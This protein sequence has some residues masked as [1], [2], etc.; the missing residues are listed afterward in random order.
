[1]SNQNI[2]FATLLPGLAGVIKLILQ[3]FGIEVPD[4][5]INDILNG[6]AALAAVI[7]VILSHHK[8]KA[9][10]TGVKPNEHNEPTIT[11]QSNK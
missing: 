10:E 6:V 7:A 5:H 3:S 11:I 1:M 2:N 4:E 9:T 8:P